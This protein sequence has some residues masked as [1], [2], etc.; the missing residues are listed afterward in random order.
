[1]RRL[2]IS[3][4]CCVSGILFGVKEEFVFCYFIKLECCCFLMYFL[5]LSWMVLS[6]VLSIVQL[7][8]LIKFSFLLF[9][10]KLKAKTKF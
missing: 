3:G 10:Q 8:L 6:L 9:F 5:F 7:L 1:M 2:I 4:R